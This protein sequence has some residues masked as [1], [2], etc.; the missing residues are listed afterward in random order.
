MSNL[1]SQP[2]EL[3][4]FNGTLS[5]Y[6]LTSYSENLVTGGRTYQS[7][8]ISRTSI[9]NASQDQEDISIIITL[10]FNHPIVEEYVFGVAPPDLTVRIYRAERDFLNDSLLMWR[11]KPLSFSVEGLEAKLTVPSVLS[12]VLSNVCPSRKYQAP[13][14]HVLFD[15]RC[16]V[17]RDSNNVHTTTVTGISDDLV[18]VQ[19]NP[20]EPGECNS[21]EMIWE[22]GGQRRMIIASSNPERL[23]I[24]LPFSRLTIGQEVTI[25]RGCNHGKTQ[26]QNKFNNFI[27]FGGFPVVPPKNPFRTTL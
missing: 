4:I 16:K 8:P 22:E 19:S 13:C 27:N 23:R 24:A 5:D 2:V 21:G 3:Y 25:T 6:Y 7:V 14:N 11:G 1:N 9:Q 12:Y 10:P 26:C 15:S 17:P 18:E 20:F